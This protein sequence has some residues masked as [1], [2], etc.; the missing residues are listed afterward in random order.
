MNYLKTALMIVMLTL[1]TLTVDA[2]VLVEAENFSHRGGWVAD[3]QAFNK[4]GSS[5]L[6]AHGLGFPVADAFTDIDVEEPGKYYVYVCTYNWTS[7]WYQGEGPGAFN[8]IVNG[9]TLPE[10]LGAKGNKWEWQYAGRAELTPKT[11]IAL[12]DLTGFNGRV[13][14]LYFS[15]ERKTPPSDFESLR[16]FRNSSLGITGPEEIPEADLVVAGGGIAGCAAALTAARYGL[17]VIL[18]DNLPELG[19]NNWLGVTMSG[20]MCYNLYPN[21]GRIVREL[22]GIPETYHQ[23]YEMERVGNGNGA[24]VVTMG[25]DELAGLRRRLLKESK[26]RV[27]HNVHI[28]QADSKE[29]TVTSVTGKDLL[30]QKEYVFRGRCFVDCTGDGEVGYLLGAEYH[31]GREPRSFAGEPTAPEQADQK[32]LGGTLNWSSKETDAES[33]FPS[34]SEIPWAVQCSDDYNVPV[35]SYA[36]TWETGFEI[37]NALEPELVRDNMLRAI[38]G[39]WAWLKSNRPDYARSELCDVAYI[40]QKRESRR[41]MGDFVLTEND[42]RGQVEY[43]DASF[44]T[45]WTLDLHYARPDNSERFPGWEWQSYCHNTEKSTWI[46]PYNVPYRV[47]YSKDFDNL[48]IGGRNMSVTHV[49]L[50]TVR[51]MATL[52]MAGEVI[53]MAAGICCR[54]NAHPSDVYTEY[55]PELIQ[56]MKSGAPKSAS[57]R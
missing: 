10:V 54:H 42:I 33:P 48:F 47:L 50:G 32:K 8:V 29:G 9:V 19:G 16:Q 22:N 51:V 11:R 44:T 40:L 23:A 4:I 45:T 14:A 18:V 24:A 26:V 28:F 43:P 25:R 31:I 12:H 30:T 57:D 15:K 39:N 20:L 37:D 7:P 56:C 52:G 27:F 2:G 46:R 38:F 13:D 55:L 5:Y 35:K 3:H 6:N 53:G 17:D 1:S 34:P 21:L 36:W 49:A 41:I